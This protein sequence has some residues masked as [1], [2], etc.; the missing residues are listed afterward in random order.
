MT[1]MLPKS[2][3]A[4]LSYFIPP[5]SIVDGPFLIETHSSFGFQT[6]HPLGFPL[7]FPSAWSLLLL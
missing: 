6:P 7:S 4:F 1:S 2:T 3:D 5:L